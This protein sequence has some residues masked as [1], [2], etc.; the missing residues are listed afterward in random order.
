LKDATRTGQEIVRRLGA[1][2]KKIDLGRTF[3]PRIKQRR[4][5]LEGEVDGGLAVSCDMTLADTR[6]IE[7]LL[8]APARVEGGESS[9]PSVTSG[10]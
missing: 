3:V 9:L 6:F 8:C 1:Q 10:R 2:E 7:N 5:C 4:R